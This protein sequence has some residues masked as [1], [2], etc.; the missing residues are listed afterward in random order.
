MGWI[1]VMAL[2]GLM[3]YYKSEVNRPKKLLMGSKKRH[4]IVFFKNNVFFDALMMGIWHKMTNF[5]PV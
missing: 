5:A 1:A 3:G 2:G 4:A